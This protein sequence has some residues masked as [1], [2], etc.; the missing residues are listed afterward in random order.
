LFSPDGK[1][2]SPPPTLLPCVYTQRETRYEEEE[3]SSRQRKI[4]KWSKQERP[5]ESF[6]R[7]V[8]C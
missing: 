5:L 7:V 2:R 1:F 4:S 8:T 6:P 3:G